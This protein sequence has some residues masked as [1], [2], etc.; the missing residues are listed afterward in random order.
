MVREV[1]RLG[2]P[3]CLNLKICIHY[4]FEYPEKWLFRYE[5]T[6]MNVVRYSLSYG[7]K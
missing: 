2:I 5:F 7:Q 1:P 4:A 6:A 3:D